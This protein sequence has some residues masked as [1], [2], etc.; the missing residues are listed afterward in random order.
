M[1]AQM[2]VEKIYRKDDA[3]KIG[4]CIPSLGM[5][6]MPW[7]S[8]MKNLAMPMNVA[9]MEC[10]VIGEEVGKARN[11]MVATCLNEGCNWIFFV[12]DDVL[13]PADALVKLFAHKRDMVSG[14]YFLKHETPQPLILRGVC[15]GIY[16]D[17]SQGD[18]VECDAHGM[19]CTLIH[20]RVFDAIMP[21]VPKD[22]RG[23]PE[24]FKTRH[25]EPVGHGLNVLSMTEDTD[26]CAKAKIAGFQPV[27]DTGVFCYHWDHRAKIAYPTKEW[28]REMQ[29]FEELMAA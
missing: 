27:V 9:H 29:K 21:N 11:E 14:V 13:L 6:S 7:H 24:W 22:A 1:N 20:K 16:T 15:G 5:V 28:K 3:V 17:W 10:Y 26:F 8:R 18:M 12:D 19:G 4:I 2:L 23:I 25:D